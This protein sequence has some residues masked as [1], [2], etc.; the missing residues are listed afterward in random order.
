MK[1]SRGFALASLLTLTASPVF[2]QFNLGDAVNWPPTLNFAR[3]VRNAIAHGKINI[4]NPN[5]PPVTWRGLTY[6]YADSGKD[7]ITQDFGLG[8]LVGLMLDA[9]DELDAMGAPTL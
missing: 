5:A 4:R 7:V 2:A 6:S 3:V 9:N 1:I 8:D